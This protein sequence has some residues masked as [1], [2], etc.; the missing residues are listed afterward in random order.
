[1][2]AVVHVPVTANPAAPTAERGVT[3]SSMNTIIAVLLGRKKPSIALPC[4][5]GF[6]MREKAALSSV[7]F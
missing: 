1:M 2:P 4:E 7:T 5:D 6:P 3:T